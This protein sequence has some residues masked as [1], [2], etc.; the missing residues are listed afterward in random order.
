MGII[1]IICD[2][3]RPHSDQAKGMRRRLATGGLTRRFFFY[4]S[5]FLFFLP[6]CLLILFVG[7][8]G[9]TISTVCHPHLGLLLFSLLSASRQPPLLWKVPSS[10]VSDIL[11][12]TSAPSPREMCSCRTSTWLKASSSPGTFIS[13]NVHRISMRYCFL[14]SFCCRTLLHTAKA[15]TSHQPTTSQTSGLKPTPLWPSATS[16]SFLGSDRMITWW[17]TYFLWWLTMHSVYLSII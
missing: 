3:C 6:V 2:R 14:S 17:D 16:E 9:I 4:C 15:V 10:W 12:A 1:H 13:V 7:F 5:F 8:R 11:L